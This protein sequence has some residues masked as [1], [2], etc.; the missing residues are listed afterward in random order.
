MLLSEILIPRG[1]SILVECI[2]E[3]QMDSSIQVKKL[4]TLTSCCLQASIRVYIEGKRCDVNFEISSQQARPN[5]S[6]PPVSMLGGNLQRPG[7][8]CAANPTLS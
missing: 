4:S 6:K 1:G 5:A 2:S 3:V 7:V 8:E